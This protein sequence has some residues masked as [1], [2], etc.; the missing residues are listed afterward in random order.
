MVDKGEVVAAVTAQDHP[1]VAATHLHPHVVVVIHRPGAEITLHAGTIVTV[2]PAENRT[3]HMTAHLAMNLVI[4]IHHP[5]EG[6]G[7]LHP[8]QMMDTG[9]HILTTHILQQRVV[10]MTI[11][12][13]HRMLT[14][15]EAAGARRKKKPQ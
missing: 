14:V 10:L 11:S 7:D 3:L 4:A 15:V 9:A 6:E 1:T 5:A 8:L 2:H 13:H 12:L